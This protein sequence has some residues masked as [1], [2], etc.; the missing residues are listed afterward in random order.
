MTPTPPSPNFDPL[1]ASNAALRAN[2]FPERPAGTPPGWF[3]G[4]VS[5]TKWVYQRFTPRYNH[6]PASPSHQSASSTGELE[7]PN[8]A[9]NQAKNGSQFNSIVAKWNVPS[10][11]SP[12]GTNAYSSIWPRLGSGNTSSN[13]LLQAGSEQDISW[14]YVLHYGW[15]ASTSYYLWWE[16]F[17]FNAQQR[18]NIAVSPLRAIFVN[19]ACYGSSTAHYYIK[20]ESTG[21]ATSF[22]ASFSGGFTG[23]NGKWIVERIQVGN[24]YP[25]LADFNNTTFS[26][27]NAEQGSTWNGVGNWSHNYLDMYDWHN[28]DFEVT[29]TYPG[30]ISSGNTFTLYW[31]NYGDTDAVGTWHG[32]NSDTCGKLTPGIGEGDR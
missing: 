8:W 5:H 31:S 12:A 14:Q 13:Q 24:N 6:Q 22:D 11:G 1:T 30:P 2:G 10:V 26:D 28:D 25:P 23:L 3:V 17:P 18:V 19:V 7:A 20:N 16:A 9:G 32:W 21:V 27:A 4:A 15:E 29:D